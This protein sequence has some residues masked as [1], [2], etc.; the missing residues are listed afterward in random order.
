M[1]ATALLVFGSVVADGLVFVGVTS[2]RN[3]RCV[4]V[5]YISVGFGLLCMGVVLLGHGER[6]LMLVL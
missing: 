2:P 5:H 1:D 3:E 4:L 6:S